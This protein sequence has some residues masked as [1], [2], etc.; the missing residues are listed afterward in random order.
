MMR[1]LVI[2][3]GPSRTTVGLPAL[4]GQSGRRLATLATIPH[5]TFL[6]LAET[7]NIFNERSDQWS[8]A[9]AIVEAA[10]IDVTG[11]RVLCLGRQVARAFGAPR[12]LLYYGKFMAK[13]GETRTE[14][15]WLFPHPS[16]VSRYWNDPEHRVLAGVFIRD[17]L[18]GRII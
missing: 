5:S 13:A 1:P 3:Q 6:A 12:S 7:T 14:S 8:A 10:K 15:A 4:S 9:L 17:F 16:S 2:G 11:R 18:A